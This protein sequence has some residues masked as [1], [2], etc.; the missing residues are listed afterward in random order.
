MKNIK[1]FIIP[2]EFLFLITDCGTTSG[3]GNVLF[4]TNFEEGWKS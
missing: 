3:V 4:G 2:A 1:I